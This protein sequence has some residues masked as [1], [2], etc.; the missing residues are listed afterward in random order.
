MV[1]EVGEAGEGLGEGGC[2]LAPSARFTFYLTRVSFFA[3]LLSVAA[4]RREQ[5]DT[6]ANYDVLKLAR[7]G[8]H[9]LTQA[10]HD[11]WNRQPLTEMKT[12]HIALSET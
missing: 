8:R 5:Q 1:V 7:L 6:G 3:A 12:T 10:S 9:S 2:P 11:Q 4:F